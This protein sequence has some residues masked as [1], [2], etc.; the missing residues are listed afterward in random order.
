M[1]AVNGDLLLAIAGL[2]GNLAVFLARFL[3]NIQF[4]A[5]L[6]GADESRAGGDGQRDDE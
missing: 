3:G 6:Y 4:R 2:L 1:Q 5:L